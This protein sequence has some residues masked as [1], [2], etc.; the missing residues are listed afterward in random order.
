MGQT[1]KQTTTITADLGELKV[2]WQAWCQAHGITPNHAIRNAIRQAM[3]RR[4]TRSP[5]SR[6][7][8]NE[9]TH[10]WK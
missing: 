6:R 10:A 2:P 4:G 9:P 5:A 1:A 3:G 7:S 8:E